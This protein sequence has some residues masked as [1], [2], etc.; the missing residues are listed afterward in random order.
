L[1]VI[2]GITLMCTTA[3]KTFR[4]LYAQ[5]FCL[6]LLEAGIAPIFMLVTGGWYKKNEAAV[7]MGAWYSATGQLGS[8]IVISV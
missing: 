5:R 8:Y 2:W 4:D 3:C 7:R 1:I 6:G